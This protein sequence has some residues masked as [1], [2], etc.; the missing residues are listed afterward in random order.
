MICH[1]WLAGN[2]A[3]RTAIAIQQ[4]CK[5]DPAQELS[6]HGRVDDAVSCVGDRGIMREEMW[7]DPLDATGI[8]GI[9][10]RRDG[11]PPCIRD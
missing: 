7:C 6:C 8:L 1:I 3:Q 5:Y 11:A 2:R 4:E 10:R 9:G